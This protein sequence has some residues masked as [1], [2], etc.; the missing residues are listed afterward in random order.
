MTEVYNTLMEDKKGGETMSPKMG[1]PTDNPKPYKI[2]V[3][4]D[5]DSHE[6]I[7]RYCKQENIEKGEAIRRGVKLLGNLIK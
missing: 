5:N 4:L 3:R 1:R 2:T 6:I 7:Q